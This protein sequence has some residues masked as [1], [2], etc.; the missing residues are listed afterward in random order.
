[1]APFTGAGLRRNRRR[2]RKR[3]SAIQLRCNGPHTT[4]ARNSSPKRENPLGENPRGMSL[5]VGTFPIGMRSLRSRSPR[6]TQSRTIHQA[7]FAENSSAETAQ[8][9]D[10]LNVGADHLRHGSL[11]LPPT[12]G[13]YLCIRRRPSLKHRKLAETLRR[14]CHANRRQVSA[15]LADS[16]T[17]RTTCTGEAHSAKR[18]PR[19]AR[20]PTRS[21]KPNADLHQKQRTTQLSK[22]TSAS[23]SRQRVRGCN[24][25][26]PPSAVGGLSQET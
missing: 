7:S 23:S 9:K 19:L 26:R 2:S 13:P 24:G 5:H 25:K 21:P 16:T 18:R 14:I 15:H 4:S 1:M 17:V 12:C 8:R 20:R 6:H 10:V 3:A 22:A 11:P